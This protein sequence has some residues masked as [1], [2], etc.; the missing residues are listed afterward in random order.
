M[1][2]R[3]DQY[4]DLDR[5]SSPVFMRSWY[6]DAVYGPDRWSAILEYRTPEIFAVLPFTEYPA[7]CYTMPP[8]TQYAGPYIHLPTS[9]STAKRYSL[10][11][12]LLDGLLK[13]LDDSQIDCYA[14]RWGTW[15][16]NWMPAFW[17]RYQNEPRY[18]YIL[19][20]KQPYKTIYQGY[21]S[22]VRNKL[23]NNNIEIVEEH[24]ID[25]IYQLLEHSLSLQ[26]KK[27]KFTLEQ[28]TVL[29]NAAF[30][31][32]SGIAVYAKHQGSYLSGAFL[33]WDDGTVYYYIAGN[34]RDQPMYHSST[35]L[36]DHCIKLACQ[37][38]KRFDL[39]GSML[40]SLSR[41]YRGFGA[42]LQS[43][44]IMTKIFTTCSELAES[45]NDDMRGFI[46]KF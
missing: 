18:T 32:E 44:P 4:S 3:P 28:I 38:D 23:K 7:H 22:Q 27:P 16:E 26:G 14:Q 37:Q 43:Y 34:N 30:Q 29:A 6:L 39:T 9:L 15:I 2:I 21:S 17:H 45:Y 11:E 25:M 31:N 13:Q 12:Q 1:I 36:I 8:V 46:F 20:C 10:Q 35:I 5:T 19:D 40:P 33:L 24:S 41:F 42:S